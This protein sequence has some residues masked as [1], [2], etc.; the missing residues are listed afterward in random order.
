M[1]LGCR[2]YVTS[3]FSQAMLC[4]LVL[5]LMWRVAPKPGTVMRSCMSLVSVDLRDKGIVDS[6]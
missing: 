1:W 5:D 4:A 2:L 3:N 6:R